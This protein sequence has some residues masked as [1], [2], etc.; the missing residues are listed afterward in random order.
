M[1]TDP[2][3]PMYSLIEN[4]ADA[5]SYE[6]INETFHLGQGLRPTPT[7]PDKQPGDVSAGGQQ[8]LFFHGWA[9][10]LLALFFSAACLTTISILLVVYHGHPVTS[11][12]EG[13]TLNAVVAVLTAAFKSSLLYT[14]SSAIGQSKWNLF[15]VRDR[16]LRDFERIDEAGKSLRGALNAL[17]NIPWSITS[18][19]AIIIILGFL[20]DPF[21]QQL[22]NTVPAQIVVESESVWTEIFTNFSITPRSDL[23]YLE[24]YSSTLLNSAFW[25]NDGLYDRQAHCSTGNCTFPPVVGLGW[26]ARTTVID[27][28]RVTSN[29]TRDDEGDIFSEIFQYQ[30]S[31]GA[32][33]TKYRVCAIYLDGGKDPL[34]TVTQSF[35]VGT[36]FELFDDPYYS[37]VNNDTLLIMTAPIEALSVDHGWAVSRDH[38]CGMWLGI[39][40]P[41]AVF[42]YMRMDELSRNIPSWLEQ[43]VLT[44]C[45]TEYE[46]TVTSG[47]TTTTQISSQPGQFILEDS[48]TDKFITTEVPTGFC[49]TSSEI[50][51]TSEQGHSRPSLN[52]SFCWN[53]NDVYNDSTI[54]GSCWWFEWFT[55][56]F[57]FYR[58]KMN[59][60]KF[61]IPFGTEREE[62][63]QADG[64]LVGDFTYLM[65]NK[66]LSGVMESLTAGMNSAW[67]TNSKERVTGSY[68]QYETI[69]QIQWEWILLPVLLNIL[70][71]VLQIVVIRQS[72]LSGQQHLWRGSVLASLYHGVD[73][74]A[75]QSDM[76]TISDMRTVADETVVRLRFS[77]GGRAMLVPQNLEPSAA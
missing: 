6:M 25:G 23:M 77:K 76:A 3:P 45:E 26:C 69:F 18:L 40:C 55:S 60:A 24:T 16:R 33:E 22:I 38:N 1:A 30:L 14:V 12:P 32:M 15:W 47:R 66:N 68:L 5:E 10:E 49:F 73:D 41:P 9:P 62:G 43:S 54:D 8:R 4:E 19:G 52:I 11:F 29:C 21:A 17:F 57:F 7:S 20:I 48:W 63:Y 51:N 65:M 31:T 36:G 67:N 64:Y 70:T 59:T 53:D 74:R 2:D 72:R 42:S 44:L 28:N 56:L 61:A 13:I 75:S 34:T 27:V 58:S 39:S 37:P 71:A 46:V 50:N 35:T